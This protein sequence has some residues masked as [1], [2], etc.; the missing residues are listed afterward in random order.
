MR[1]RD[2]WLIGLAQVLAF[3]P[4]VSRSGATI[5]AGRLL[6]FDRVSA[7]RFS[8][9]M[10]TPVIAAAAILQVP[11]AVAAGA[12]GPELFAGAAAAALSGTLAIGFLLRFLTVR[13]FAA[14][15]G[16]RVALGLIVYAIAL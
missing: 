4:G 2:A 6:S 9:L 14:F 16:Y 13:G 11:E 10:S 1:A 15:A 3:V 8:F 12:L 7:A 5:T